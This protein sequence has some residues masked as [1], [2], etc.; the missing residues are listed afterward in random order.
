MRLIHR[1]TGRPVQIGDGVTVRGEPHVV[2]RFRQPHK[3]SSEGRVIVRPCDEPF[4]SRSQAEYYVSIAGLEWIERED[5]AAIPDAVAR[6]MEDEPELSDAV[7]AA[8]DIDD[9]EGV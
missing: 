4:C 9:G 5:R 2:V 3:P 7:A 6:A 8:W 1:S